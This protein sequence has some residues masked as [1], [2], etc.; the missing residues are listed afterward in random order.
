MMG[1]K[2]KA[3]IKPK[4]I[5]ALNPLMRKGKCHE[6]PFKSKRKASRQQL[7]KESLS[8]RPLS[9]SLSALFITFF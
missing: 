6:K 1:K 7:R 8:W 3:C 9:L 4:N 2:H 5:H